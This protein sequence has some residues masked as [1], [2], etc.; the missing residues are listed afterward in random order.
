MYRLLRIWLTFLENTVTLSNITRN[1]WDEIATL[2]A[3]SIERS[4]KTILKL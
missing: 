1:R 2:Y 4:T 3:T